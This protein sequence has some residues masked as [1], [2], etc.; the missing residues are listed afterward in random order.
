MVPG[1]KEKFILIA[2]F[3]SYVTSLVYLS[4]ELYKISQKY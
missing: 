3:E 1:G 4:M 2:I